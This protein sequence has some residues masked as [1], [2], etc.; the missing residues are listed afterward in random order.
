M[1]RMVNLAAAIGASWA[2]NPAFAA[3]SRSIEPPEQI[4]ALRTCRTIADIDNRA[5]CY[6]R[7][8]DALLIAAQTRQIVFIDSKELKATRRGLF[9]FSLPK[10]PFLD[11][12][13]SK[14]EADEAR[15][16]VAK[17]SGVSS[18]GYGKLRVRLEDGALWDTIDPSADLEDLRSGDTVTLLKGSLGAYFLEWRNAHVQARRLV[19]R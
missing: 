1:R 12:S 15:R 6:D 10:L 13:S 5:A 3:P 14:E 19:T 16:L 2:S 8:T 4:A 17:V 18:A 11:N 9:G 7:A